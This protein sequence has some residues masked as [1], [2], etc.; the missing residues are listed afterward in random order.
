MH[1]RNLHYVIDFGMY[2]FCTYK[3]LRKQ[4]VLLLL[5]FCLIYGEFLE[6]RSSP[7]W[8]PKFDS[9]HSENETRLLLASD[10]H[11]EGYKPNLWWL[12]YL[13]QWDSD[14][15]LKY[16]FRQALD[17]V[18]PNGFLILGDL[19]DLG[20]EI[21]EDEFQDTCAR[22]QHIFLDRNPLPLIVVMYTIVL[23][24]EQHFI[25]PGDNDV[26]LIE[27]GPTDPLLMKRLDGCLNPLRTT[28]N[29]QF[30]HLKTVP[31]GTYRLP[32]GDG[33][34]QF[35]HSNEPFFILATHEPIMQ[36]P[37]DNL[38]AV[39]SDKYPCLFVSSHYHRPY[40]Y[41]IRSTDRGSFTHQWTYRPDN[42]H[43]RQLTLHLNLSHCTTD[44]SNP[45]ESIGLGVPSCTYRSG[46]PKNTAFA[47]LQI[48]RD[49]RATYQL[50]PLSS[51]L[52]TV[53]LYL[54]CIIFCFLY[55]ILVT[56][57]QRCPTGA[58]KHSVGHGT[59]FK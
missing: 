47:V 26:D 53:Y 25:L 30:L 55:M 21:D 46:F 13:F 56:L 4:P 27:G 2:R 41:V 44:R 33:K 42:W 58:R 43:P 48:Y 20:S 36:I 35:N 6:P 31:R 10:P 24:F 7:F 51:R 1:H 45:H 16:H 8:W 3:G 23:L 12:N 15:Y 59:M 54:V 19:F 39:L 52:S 28:V 38:N 37:R 14:R 49:G 9:L 5:L 50:L 18:K 34:L 32:S 17:W 40:M 11:L 22:F 57:L 29:I